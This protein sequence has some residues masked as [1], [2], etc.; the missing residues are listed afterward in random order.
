MA[1]RQALETP[2]TDGSHTP[3]PPVFN[4]MTLSNMSPTTQLTPMMTTTNDLSSIPVLKGK[5]N[6]SQWLRA[7][8]LNLEARDVWHLCEDNVTK[9]ILQQHRRT[10]KWLTPSLITRMADH[11]QEQALADELNTKNPKDVLKW[12]DKKFMDQGF[13]RQYGIYCH[14]LDTTR[15]Q[16]KKLEEFTTA[17]L[18]NLA[19]VNKLPDYKVS[20]VAACAH[21]L[22]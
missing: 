19:E 20:D 7:V 15:D 4:P 18:Q 13:N 5:Q 10:A 8:Q 1:E 3:E 16:Y 12:V 2:I 17:Y 6:A 14:W 22:R 21:F 9:T 11:L